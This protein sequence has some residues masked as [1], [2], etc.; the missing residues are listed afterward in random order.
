MKL[1][2]K[3][4]DKLNTYI[5]KAFSKCINNNERNFMQEALKKVCEAAKTKGNLF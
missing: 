2:V 3:C 4:S 5:E 1:G